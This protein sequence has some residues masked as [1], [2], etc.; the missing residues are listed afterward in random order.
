MPGYEAPHG[1]TIQ[2]HILVTSLRPDLSLVNEAVRKAIVFE[3]TCPWDSNVDRSHNYKQDKYAPLVADLSQNFTVYQF[4]VEVSVRGQIS[5]HNKERIK[6]FIYRCCVSPGKLARRAVE[7][8]SKASLLSSYSIFC[9]RKEPAW[10]SPAP[11][12]VR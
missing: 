3:L 11:L 1:G 8:S 12:T 7:N 10:N 2:P 9:A 5:K 4:S 6:A